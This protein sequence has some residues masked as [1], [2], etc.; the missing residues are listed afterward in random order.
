MK[1]RKRKRINKNSVMAIFIVIIMISSILGFVWTN[2]TTNNYEYKG[3]K[4]KLQGNSFILNI[5][6]KQIN[7]NYLPNDIENIEIS[8]E[9]KLKIKNNPMLYLSFDTDSKNIDY[10]DKARFELTNELQKTNVYAIS[11]KTTNSTNYN[12]PIITCK[13]ATTHVPVI[14]LKNGNT[15][16]FSIKDN[17]IIAESSSKEG[18][19]A[20]KDL[21]IYTVFNV[22]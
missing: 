4:F 1:D 15:T 6:N 14:Y 11:G 20:L 22:I 19:I 16:Q 13:N 5:N 2:I 10:M 21:I 8:K 7:T 18:F 12:I 9:I 17:C 3:H